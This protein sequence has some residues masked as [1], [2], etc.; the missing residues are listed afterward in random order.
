MVRNLRSRIFELVS[1]AISVIFEKIYSPL[2]LF[3]LQSKSLSFL[4][5][6][7]S[8]VNDFLFAVMQS[9]LKFINSL[10][11]NLTKIRIVLIINL[12]SIV[13]QVLMAIHCNFS[14]HMI[15]AVSK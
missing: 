13:I 15:I 8:F 4:I 7:V 1:H 11:M 5:P 10:V 2:E 9:V 3:I 14:S 12:D 6:P